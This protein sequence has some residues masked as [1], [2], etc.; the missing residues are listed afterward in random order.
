MWTSDAGL[1]GAK[2]LYYHGHPRKQCRKKQSTDFG[3]SGRA[4]SLPHS[5]QEDSLME[6]L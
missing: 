1:L 3:C 4:L 2:F 5:L 6:G